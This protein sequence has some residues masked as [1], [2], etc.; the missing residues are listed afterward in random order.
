MT[1]NA[2]AVW[3]SFYLN[4]ILFGRGVPIAKFILWRAVNYLNLKQREALLGAGDYPG[5]A[6]SV[7]KN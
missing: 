3:R 7:C 2:S 1:A 6:V 5:R 4:G